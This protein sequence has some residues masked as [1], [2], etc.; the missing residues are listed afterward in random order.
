MKGN[1][2]LTPA[3]SIEILPEN[4]SRRSIVLTKLDRGGG[5]VFL[6]FSQD[7]VPDEGL[8]LGNDFDAIEILAPRAHSAIHGYNTGASD[9]IVTFQD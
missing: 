7:A 4:L 1:K 6:A 2:T 8:V 9:E 3:A 5:S